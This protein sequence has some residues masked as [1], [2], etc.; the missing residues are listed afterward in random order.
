MERKGFSVVVAATLANGI[1]SK[2]KLPWSLPQEM[3]RFKQLTTTTDKE[4]KTNAVIMGRKTFESIPPKFRPLRDRTNVVISTQPKQRYGVIDPL[5]FQLIPP[6]SFPEN[7]HVCG[8]LNAAIELVES[9]HLRDTIDNVF[10]IGGAQVYQEALQHPRCATIHLTQ[11]IS[12]PFECDTFFPPIDP[13][14]FELDTTSDTCEEQGVQYKFLKYSRKKKIPSLGRCSPNLLP[15]RRTDIIPGEGL[16]EECQYLNLV[17]DIIENGNLKED[18]TGTGKL[19]S[20][21]INFF[22]LTI[23]KERIP[24]LACR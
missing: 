23:P 13:V 4:N 2:G 19:K 14:I 16:H 6:P 15:Q 20:P 21:F 12:P 1:G 3:A 22:F 18:R 5:D 7:V 17:R 10:V 9:N 24:S 11:I 8:D